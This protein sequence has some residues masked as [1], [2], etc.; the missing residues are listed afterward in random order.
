MPQ[1][2]NMLI[3]EAIKQLLSVRSILAQIKEEDYTSPLKTLRGASIGKHIRHIV[4]FYEC[5][6]FAENGAVVNYDARKRNLLLEE[7][8]KYTEDFVTEVIDTLE[9]IE[10]N[11]RILLVSN[12]Q[13]KS[14]H[15]E[16]SVYREIIYN[17]E[18]TVH[19]LAIISI[20]IPIHFDYIS[21]ASNFGYAESTIQYLKSQKAS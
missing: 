11:S 17:I 10:G 15:T 21:L 19:H 5:L 12:Y 2:N 9:K 1:K 6:L 7:S 18:H 3:Q 14:I 13:E 20:A 16:S 8:V 4:E